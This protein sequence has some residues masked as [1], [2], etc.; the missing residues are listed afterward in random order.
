MQIS[1]TTANNR[2]RLVQVWQHYFKLTTWRLVVVQQ[3]SWFYTAVEKKT[4]LTP[5]LTTS[6][7]RSL[8]ALLSLLAQFM[9][10][11]ELLCIILCSACRQ[12]AYSLFGFS[13]NRKMCTVFVLFLLLCLTDYLTCML[14]IVSIQKY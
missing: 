9:A 3:Y 8:P 6:W 12:V 4:P 13:V 2:H 10:L 14:Y 5:L 7:C 1:S 11:C